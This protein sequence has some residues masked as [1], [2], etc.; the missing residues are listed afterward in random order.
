MEWPLE[1][2]SDDTSD[3]SSASLMDI[4]PFED[5]DSVP[6]PLDSSDE[7]DLVEVQKRKGRWRLPPEILSH[8]LRYAYAN[9]RRQF[10]NNAL[11]N[12]EWA[13]CALPV[14]WERIA[15]RRLIWSSSRSFV[16]VTTSDSSPCTAISRSPL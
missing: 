11:V 6:S 3:S 4:T 12:K 14:L 13:A 7:A 8:V 5:G 15:P 16:Y 2:L 9:S 10:L 1:K